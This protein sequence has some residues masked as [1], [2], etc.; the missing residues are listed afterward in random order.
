MVKGIGIDIVSIRRIE[1]MF[2]MYGEKFVERVLSSHEKEKLNKRVKKGEFLAGRF[3]AK[4]AIT[5]VLEK[6]IAFMNLEILDNVYDK[7]YLE[8]FPDIVISISHEDD[9][10][11]AVAIRIELWKL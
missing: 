2:Y 3:A 11:V 6:P 4:E 1:K 10:A 8:G 7:P 9:F 5:K